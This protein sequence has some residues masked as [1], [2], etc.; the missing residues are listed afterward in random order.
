MKE[1]KFYITGMISAETLGEV[2]RALGEYY[3]VNGANGCSIC[4]T[5]KER[6]AG[7]FKLGQGYYHERGQTLRR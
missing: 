2:C 7:D 6:H 4:F 3:I 5:R 1:E